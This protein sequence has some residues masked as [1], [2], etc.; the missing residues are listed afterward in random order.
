[1]KYLGRFA[2]VMSALAFVSTVGYAAV[3]LLVYKGALRA[4]LFLDY[5]LAAGVAPLV[6]IILTYLLRMGAG[7]WMLKAGCPAQA[8]A[9]AHRRRKPGI[10]VGPSEA[11]INRYVAAESIRRLGKPQ[12]AL[13]I[14]DEAVRPPWRA[15]LRVL[16][17]EARK[18]ALDD[19]SQ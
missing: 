2:V 6:L 4:P 10:F 7:R 18:A 11:A 8:F 13:S 19:L 5:G 16:Q 15:Q 3:F 17:E 14:L 12:E 9:Y 1:M